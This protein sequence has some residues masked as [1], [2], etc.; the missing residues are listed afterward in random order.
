V[1]VKSVVALGALQQATRLFP[2]E[3]FLAAIE[4]ALREKG[5]LL[6]LNRDAFARGVEAAG[7]AAGATT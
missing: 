5:P 4:Q 7:A 6:S 1:K 3:T 2:A